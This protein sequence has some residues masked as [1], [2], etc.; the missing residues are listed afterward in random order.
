V[1]IPRSNSRA[2]V[3]ESRR[4]FGHDA[5]LVNPGALV[6]V[7][8]TSIRSGEGPLVIQP[9]LENDPYRD[10]SPLGTGKS[11]TVEGVMIYSLG[12]REDQDVVRVDVLR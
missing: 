11:I 7:V 8:D 1:I 2:V 3:V 5:R 12:D 6:Y 4:R 10:R 9:A